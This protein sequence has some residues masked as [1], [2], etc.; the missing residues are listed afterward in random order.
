MFVRCT[1]A[2]TVHYPPSI[3]VALPKHTVTARE[4]LEHLDALHRFA[5]HLSPTEADDLVQE[6]FARALASAD[7]FTEG[8][9]I[10]AWLFRILRNF[11]VDRVRRAKKAPFVD[12]DIERHADDSARLRGDAE[13]ELLRNVVADDIVR[14]LGALTDDARAVIAL[15]LEGFSE[16]EIADVLSIPTGTVKSRLSRAR[17]ALRERLQEYAR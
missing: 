6:T 17:A 7:G 14:A 16:A 13:L 8:T 11:H 9:S 15:D 4:A 12:G 10:R 2:I 5:R 3:R 1:D